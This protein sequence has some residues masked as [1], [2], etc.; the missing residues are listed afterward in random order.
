[1]HFITADVVKR[2]E[3]MVSVKPILLKDKWKLLIEKFKS[4]VSDKSDDI[5]PSSEDWYSLTLDWV[6]SN[7]LDEVDAHKFATYIRYQTNLK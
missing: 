7:G 4:E 2:I 6:I 5:D 3:E 1:M